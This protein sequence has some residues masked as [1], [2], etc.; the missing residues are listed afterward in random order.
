MVEYVKNFQLD[1]D[2][3]RKRNQTIQLIKKIIEDN[4]LNTSVILYGSYPQGLSTKFSD[5]DFTVKTNQNI[6]L[7]NIADILKCEFD[8]IKK[9]GK[10]VPIIKA[11]CKKTNI[12]VDISINQKGE[13]AANSIRNIISKNPFLKYV[14]IVLKNILEPYMNTFYGGI[15]SFLL[16][17]LIYYFYFVSEKSKMFFIMLIIFSIFIV[18]LNMNYMQ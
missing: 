16:F 8:N 1:D 5:L 11:R 17:H 2:S 12:F 3:I 4:Y 14:F 7:D 13:K 9:V 18:I 6:N 10:N 15:S